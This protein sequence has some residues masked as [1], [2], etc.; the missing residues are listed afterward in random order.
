MVNPAD[1]RG[2]VAVESAAA[3]GRPTTRCARSK[4]CRCSAPVR[5]SSWCQSLCPQSGHGGV[6]VRLIQ[7]G[8]F[9]WL[10]PMRAVSTPAAGAT[11]TLL[12]GPAVG[13]D[14]QEDSGRSRTSTRLYS[15]LQ[16]ERGARNESKRTVRS[17][18]GGSRS[19]ICIAESICHIDSAIQIRFLPRP[20]ADTAAIPGLCGLSGPWPEAAG[21]PDPVPVSGYRN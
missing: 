1:H 11:E 12:R 6:F 15:R 9:R 19:K 3:G 21:A 2:D 14:H 18:L 17:L 10:M 4:R 16:G 8:R 5:C 20:R 13:W 7:G